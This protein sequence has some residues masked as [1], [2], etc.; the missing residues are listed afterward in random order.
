MF[1][2]SKASASSGPRVTSCSVAERSS[3]ILERSELFSLRIPT[4]PDLNILFRSIN[5]SNG[6]ST[7]AFTW[8]SPISIWISTSSPILPISTW[9][10]P[11]P[12]SV[13]SPNS[14]PL[15]VTSSMRNL[16]STP[17]FPITFLKCSPNV[18]SKLVPSKNDSALTNISFTSIPASTNISST[19][20]S[21]CTAISRSNAPQSTKTS[22]Q[23]PDTPTSTTKSLPSLSTAQGTCETSFLG[24]ISTT[25]SPPLL[26]S[27]FGFS[28][29][30]ANLGPRVTSW[31]V[32]ERSSLI[33]WRSE[34]FSFRIPTVPAL[35]ILF[36]S[37]NLSN[38]SSTVAF[39]WTSPISIWI[40]T[41][42][43]ILPISTWTS[44]SPTSEL[45]P[46][47]RP[48]T[49]TS[50]MTILVSTP[51]FPITFL[52]CSPNLVS[53]LVPSKNDSASTNIS[54]TSIPAS[55]NMS[56]TSKSSCTAISRSNAPQS[57]KTSWQSPDTP[58]STTK[59]RR[60]LPP[61]AQGTCFTTSTLGMNST[62][63][64]SFRNSTLGS[65]KAFLSAEP[66]V[67]SV[68]NPERISLR[69][70][71]PIFS[72][73]V[74]FRWT[75]PTLMIT[76]FPPVGVPIITSTSFLLVFSSSPPSLAIYPR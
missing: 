60:V 42:S 24:I 14:R 5:L 59:S 39:T 7:V 50:S 20:K 54:F 38:R 68:P 33:L 25:R 23:S 65:P 36:R 66:K 31:T 16:V 70:E 28:R 53:I 3:L 67:I 58:T 75:S 11:S 22:W 45:S 4:V 47:S 62:T 1:G 13:L 44:P 29:A 76:S 40:S 48:L 2:L 63:R 52:K 15:T 9:T 26:T 73:P 41:S 37:I 51:G 30:S 71:S 46:N 57:T 43:P 72:T 61:K 21:S 12:T 6:S 18:V 8:T 74:T 10:S 56:S 34:L 27:M 32:A 35:N 55:T 17:G 69:A 64:S 49:V 19:S